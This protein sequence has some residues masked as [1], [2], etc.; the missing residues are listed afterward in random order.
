M[1]MAM[2][3]SLKAYSKRTSSDRHEIHA[4]QVHPQLSLWASAITEC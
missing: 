4:V 1:V 3:N 2:D